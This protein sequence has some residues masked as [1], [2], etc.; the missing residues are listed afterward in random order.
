MLVKHHGD[1]PRAVTLEEGVDV[2]HL[3]RTTK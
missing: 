2:A 3:M 1:L